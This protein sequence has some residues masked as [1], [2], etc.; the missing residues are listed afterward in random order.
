[1]F[2]ALLDF[3]GIEKERLQFSWISA[4]EGKKF[5]DVVTKI[6]NDIKMIGPFKGYQEMNRQFTT[7]FPE[8]EKEKLVQQCTEAEA[9]NG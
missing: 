6:T 2:H 9:V 1:M 4:S 3:A 7:E 5:A 8:Q